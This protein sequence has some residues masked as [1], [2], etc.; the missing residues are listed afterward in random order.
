MLALVTV[1]LLA[2]SCGDAGDTAEGGGDTV[3]NGSVVPTDVKFTGETFTVLCREDNAWGRYL[4]EIAADEDATE[5]V[6]EAVY[7]RNLQVEE[8]FEL[9]KLEAY[10]IPGQWAVNEDFINTAPLILL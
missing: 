6:N 1:L 8:R 9:E 2:V 10:A 5:L 3:G 7:K 4:H